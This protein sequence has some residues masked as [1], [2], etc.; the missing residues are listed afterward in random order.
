MEA[1]EFFFAA[2]FYLNDNSL[3]ST[4]YLKSETDLANINLRFIF[5][6]FNMGGKKLC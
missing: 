5:V 1:D 4:V 3:S 6:R 2:S